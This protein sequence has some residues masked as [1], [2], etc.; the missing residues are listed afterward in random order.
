MK[1]LII[2]L[3]LALTGS[4][5]F[6]Q[7]FRIDSLP[8][9]GI[10]LNKGWTYHAGDNPAWA[11]PDFDDSHWQ[12][13]D[14]T[15]DIFELPQ[16]DKTA[17]KIGW[18]RLR[19]LV[20]SS[21][22]RQLVIEISQSGASEIY[23]NGRLIHQLGVLIT[24]PDRID[25]FNPNR[26]PISFPISKEKIQVLAVRYALQPNIAYGKNFRTINKAF[27]SYLIT[28]ENAAELYSNGLVTTLNRDFFR[29]A[30]YAILFVI[31]LALYLV[32]PLRCVFRPK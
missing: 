2:T 13:I 6:A 20:D 8:A 11:N 23:L 22:N 12:A 32:S 7:V 24:K 10:L 19:L 28:D 26:K 3:F 16:L 31:F 14:P 29:V 5:G 21:L 15:K 4:V 1:A 18:F 25:A 27:D 17:G 30:V 9:T